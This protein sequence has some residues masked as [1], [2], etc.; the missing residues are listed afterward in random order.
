MAGLFDHWLALA[1]AR[2][3]A[4]RERPGAPAPPRRA[5]LDP[6]RFP[7]ALP[8]VWLVDYEPSASRFVYRLAGDHVRET[9]GR[10][11]KGRALAEVIVDQTGSA[12]AYERFLETLRRPAALLVTGEVYQAANA[13]YYG[14]RLVL[15]LCGGEGDEPSA[16]L[17]VTIPEIQ[18]PTG[19][20]AL[21]VEHLFTPLTTLL[22]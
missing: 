8:F 10:P 9:L 12:R 4:R 21:P 11:V 19:A 5:D 3:A 7:A 16:I 22:R 6:M 20:N 17:G 1:A 2:A 18:G 13:P 15:P 14:Q